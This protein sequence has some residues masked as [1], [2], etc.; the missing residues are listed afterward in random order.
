MKKLSIYNF[1]DLSEDVQKTIISEFT[2]HFTPAYLTGD[3]LNNVNAEVALDEFYSLVDIRVFDPFQQVKD[4]VQIGP[5]GWSEWLLA[6][7][8]PAG[9]NVDEI[10]EK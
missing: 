4:N 6:Y 1:Y 10:I 7:T 9:N 8:D 2:E 3:D 5:D